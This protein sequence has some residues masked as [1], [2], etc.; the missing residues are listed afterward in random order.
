MERTVSSFIIRI[1][2]R[3]SE[4]KLR[5]L[6]CSTSDVCASQRTNSQAPRVSFK[7]FHPNGCS[8]RLKGPK[9]EEFPKEGLGKILGC[10][11]K[12]LPLYQAEDKLCQRL[13]TAKAPPKIPQS[14]TGSSL[15]SLWYTVS[16][17]CSQRML[18]TWS[19]LFL[20]V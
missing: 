1:R 16:S 17:F 10:H 15:L 18:F 12:P 2:S 6:H 3:A 19:Q 20:P 7:S 13:K 14:K 5:H 8:D 11:L 9:P 4:L